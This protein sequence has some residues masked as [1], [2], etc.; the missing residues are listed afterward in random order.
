[1]IIRIFG[2]ESLGVRGLSCSVEL[3]NQK[4]FID[5]GLALGWSRHGLLP[6][7]FQVAVGAGIR[8]TIIE[9][10]K[11]ADDVVF[12]HFH[13]DHCPLKKANPYQLDLS[14]VKKSLSGCRIWAKSSENCSHTE[15]NRR[16]DLIE[17][18]NMSFLKTEGTKNG[19]LEFSRPVFHGLKNEKKN[20]VIMTRIEDGGQ[21]FVHA[22]DIQLLE[23]ATIETILDWKPDIVLVSGPPLY[24]FSASSLKKNSERAW[25]NALELSKNI[26]TLIIDHHLLR[27]EQG[28]NWHKKLKQAAANKI[29][30]AADFM[31]R[32]PLFLEAWRGTLYEGLPVS[33]NWHDDYHNA[34]Q[35]GEADLTWYRINGWPF[36]IRKHKLSPCRWY[37]CCPI[38]TY[39]ENGNLE[40]YW[41][42]NYCLVN[43]RTCLRYQM[44]EKGKFHPDNMLPDG[45][46]RESL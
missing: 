33:D 30:C 21:V 31:K 1:M 28:I 40:R 13:G 23:S 15:E 42:E 8:E 46:I 36:L 9:E 3:E 24:I 19:S 25:E 2:A 26:D 4:I 27:S 12:S 29:F 16:I 10:L 32:S 22:S 11:A 14:R 43:N 18:V 34:Y 45:T 44:E 20:T 39:T 37:E 5:P 7:P 6:H 38:K 41:E 35:K 17:A